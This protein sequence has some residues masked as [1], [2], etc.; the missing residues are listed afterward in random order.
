METF[1]L[2]FG[3]CW[4]IRALGRNPLVRMSDRVEALVLVLAFATVLIVTPAAGA[5]ST[6]FHDSHARRYAEEARI[7]HPVSATVTGDTT[8][9]IRS[10][11]VLVTV[12]V[13]WH[14][15]GVEHVGKLDADP[16]TKVGD[17]LDIWVDRSGNEVG[18]PAATWRAGS[19]ALFAGVGSWLGLVAGVAGL[20]AWVCAGLVRRRDMGW[21]RE[22][23]TLVDDG[24]GR[25]GSRT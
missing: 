20:A 11:R 12:P 16:A 10:N 7:R 24:G 23:K 15:D 13:R 6:A 8:A 25:S 4:V 3:R 2:G 9:T 18:A 1:T 21:D 17:R 14:V 22:L 19:D 5:I